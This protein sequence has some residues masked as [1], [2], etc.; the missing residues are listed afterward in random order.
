MADNRIYFAGIGSRETPVNMRPMI[1]QIMD[2]LNKKGWILR[3]GGAEGADT[4]FEK[5][6]KWKEIYL[7]WKGFNNNPSTTFGYSP[8][9]EQIAKKFHPTYEQLSRGAKAC[10]SRNSY[11]VLGG[12]LKTPAIC[13]ICYTPTGK[14]TGGTGQAIRIAEAHNIPVFNLKNRGAFDELM[15]FIAMS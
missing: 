10:M 12:D 14:A 3:S 6:A 8:E 15:Q 9:A 1:K 2:T 13:V 5:F 7:P 4:F 11:Q